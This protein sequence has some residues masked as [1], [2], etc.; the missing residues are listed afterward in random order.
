VRAALELPRRE[1]ADYLRA[2]I[3][4]IDL[5]RSELAKP[6]LEELSRLQLTD[7][8]R[9]A[10]VNE[11]GSGTMLKLARSEDLAPAGAQFADACMAA[12][13][14]AANDPQRI[15]RLVA[16][17]T[18]P[19]L[20]VRVAARNDLAATGRTGVIATLEALARERVA[21][22]RAAI[23]D[24]A[25]A[26]QPLVAGPLL[27]M[28]STDDA[29][30]RAEVESLL[31]QLGF[32]QA[33]PF[34]HQSPAAAEQ[35]LVA[36]IAR[37][38]AGTP[39]FA[40]DEANR[41]EI[42]HWNDAASSLSSA[43]YSADDAR[44]IW[45]ARLARAL[46]QLRPN[47]RLY[48]RQAWVLGLQA[49]GLVGAPAVSLASLE[50]S[51]VNDVLG[52]ALR[53]DYA[54]AAVAAAHELGRR[55]DSHVLFTSS[56]DP[57]PLANALTHANRGVRF[58]AL[59]SIMALDPRSPFPGS[60][61]VPKVLAWFAKGAGERRAV[62]AMPTNLMAT[63]LAGM[64]SARGLEADA[65]NHGRAAIDRARDLA[66]LEMIFVDM[67]LAGP[68]VR[69]VLYELRTA[70]ETGQVPIALLAADGRLTAARRL[71]GEHDRVISVPRP[72]TAEVL[73][74]SVDA[75]NELAAREAESANE[76]AMQAMQAMNWLAKLLASDHSFYDL[77]RTAPAIEAALYHPGAARLALPSLSRLGTPESQQ[78]LVNFASETT[79]PI[80]A[81]AQA[82][83]AFAASVI[84]F[85]LLLT[86]DEILTQ[87]DRYN[88]SAT[89][90]GETQRVLSQLL[91]VI[92]S[93]H[94][95]PTSTPTGL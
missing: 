16:E 87:Y 13:A 65:T 9:A 74:R 49:A 42:W 35:A 15:A 90:D 56:G 79:L 47:N 82:A 46:A 20:E 60:S 78:L 45:M 28:L 44:V 12:A 85:G 67:D 94:A 1:P 59:Q 92:E 71:A 14:A 86:T 22:R 33:A 80:P 61:R 76:R 23:A 52:D 21:E 89:A 75:L 10:L 83:E 48:Q 8:Q 31:A 27:A 64:L 2:V 72:H 4:L 41:A 36:A 68:D 66:D 38:S 25:A 77:H 91:D 69:Q 63:D 18:D 26:M 29:A 53:S 43:R 37:Y 40:L 6:I 3:W 30:L 81:R 55:R 54:H 32:I 5:G 73:G 17:L 24:A 70:P 84:K 57:S 58:A 51:L 93:R 88:A 62:V 11:F 50:T 95:Q 7:K 34:L 19:S 39:P